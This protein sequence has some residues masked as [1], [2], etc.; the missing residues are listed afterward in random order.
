[1]VIYKKKRVRILHVISDTYSITGPANSLLTL[2]DHFPQD[3]YHSYVA[4]REPGSLSEEIRERGEECIFLSLPKPVGLNALYFC[5]RLPL[6]VL[7]LIAF[8]RRYNINL[9]HV[10]QS[11]S[12]WGLIAGRLAGIPVVFHAREMIGNRAY[13]WVILHLSTRTIA[14]SHAVKKYLS[15]SANLSL[16]DNISVVY[17]AIDLV[18]FDPAKYDGNLRDEWGIPEHAL[19]V[20]MISK[21]IENK[22]H[23]DFIKSCKLLRKR[24]P[25]AV[26][27]IVGGELPGH[28]WYAEN[29]KRAVSEAGLEDVLHLVGPRRDVERF[30]AASDLVV[31]PSTCEEGL[32]RV[33]IE[34]MG[35]GKPVV[36]TAVGGIPEV[37]VD[38]ITGYLVPKHNP[39]ALAECIMKLLGDAKLRANFGQAG[40]RRAHDIFNV[41]NHV[42]SI[43]RIYDE[44]VL[45]RKRL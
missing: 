36:A 43:T 44:V 5:F 42:N 1:M 39:N 19:L 2:L 31:Q 23:L 27:M 26:F 12:I 13:K 9:I 30:L 37:V 17:N 24:V 40:Q 32:G 15:L 25:E 18:R 14:I 8:I 34:A 7:K 10:H 41:R 11:Q 3:Y 20:L 21:L 28:E 45:S 38:S 4:L 16:R 33:P 29:V 6:A 22:G 35:L